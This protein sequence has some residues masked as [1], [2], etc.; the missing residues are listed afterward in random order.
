MLNTTDIEITLK[1]GKKYEKIF[2]GCIQFKSVREQLKTF[3]FGENVIFVVTD[4]GFVIKVD[5]LNK[6]EEETAKKYVQELDSPANG[7]ICKM[8]K[9]WQDALNFAV[10]LAT[11]ED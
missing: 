1:N 11:T 7:I 10:D 3:D 6:E 4:Y 2:D 5:V 8:L 9:N